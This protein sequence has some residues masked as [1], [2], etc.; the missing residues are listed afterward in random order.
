MIFDVTFG[1]F[2]FPWMPHA[3]ISFIKIAVSAYIWKICVMCQ[4]EI[5]SSL[6]FQFFSVLFVYVREEK[7]NDTE[8]YHTLFIDGFWQALDIKID[9]YSEVC[10]VYVFM[11]FATILENV[12]TSFWSL[13]A[14]KPTAIVSVKNSSTLNDENPFST[15]YFATAA[16]AQIIMNEQR[17]YI[18]LKAKIWLWLPIEKINKTFE[19]APTNR[20]STTKIVVQ[21][22]ISLSNRQLAHWLLFARSVVTVFSKC[23]LLLLLL[24]FILFT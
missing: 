7:R 23:W 1:M 15:I 10:R 18:Y 4:M 3:C 19:N 8:C 21:P 5:R 2:V 13:A 22:S 17:Y 20:D 24:P 12:S 6:W 16:A 9:S 14:A 11:A